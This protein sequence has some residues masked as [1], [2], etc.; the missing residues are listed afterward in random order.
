MSE[1]ETLIEPGQTFLVDYGREGI[2]AVQAL[3]ACGQADLADIVI[4]LI[5]VENKPEKDPIEQLSIFRRAL[6]A[7]ALCVADFE[8]AKAS[9]ELK[10]IDAEAAVQ[11]AMKCLA[12]QRLSEDEQ[13][14]SE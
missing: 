7:L 1:T 6:D 11:I 4:E 5:K 8:A 13:K 9:G 14:K 2:I 12:K 3:D 10:K